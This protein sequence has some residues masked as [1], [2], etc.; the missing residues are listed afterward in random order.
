[1]GKRTRKMMVQL[2]PV[3][4]IPELVPLVRRRAEDETAGNVSAY[5]RQLVITDILEHDLLSREEIIK[6]LRVQ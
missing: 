5:L 3:Q 4:I 6:M 1:M 2:G